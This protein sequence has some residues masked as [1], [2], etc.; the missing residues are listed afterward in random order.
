MDQKDRDR[1]SNWTQA[2]KVARDTLKS[3]EQRHFLRR[4]SQQDNVDRE[5]WCD[6]MTRY[7]PI[8]SNVSRL[9]KVLTIS[10]LSLVISEESL[11]GISLRLAQTSL[12]LTRSIFYLLF[13][14][15]K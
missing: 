6:S 1:I 4:H 12:H 14:T 2:P 7:L 5:G 9:R 11:L 10:S 8:S 3:I 15:V 13:C